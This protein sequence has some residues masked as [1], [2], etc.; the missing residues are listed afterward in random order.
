[1]RHAYSKT[2]IAIVTTALVTA[3]SG[4]ATSPAAPSSPSAGPAVANAAAGTATIA[5]S[6]NGGGVTAAFRPTSVGPITVSIAGSSMTTNVDGSGRFTLR[7]VPS[8]D[9]TLVFSSNG[10]N[11][12][13]VI[14]GVADH[15]QIQISVALSG[16]TAALDE[17]ERDEANNQAELEGRLTAINAAARTFV[18]AGVTVTVPTGTPVRHGDTAV[19]LSALVVGER[20]H[21][22]GTK[23]AANAMTA[24]EVEVQNEHANPGPGDDPGNDGHGGGE[25]ELEG[26]LSGL[27]GTCPTVTFK[28]SSATVMTNASTKFEDTTCATLSSAGRVEVKGTKQTNGSVLATKVEKK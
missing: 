22:H 10:V 23:T 1:M 18:V 14:A 5:G 15:E 19:A 8:G 6:V 2:V 26:T 12:Q 16:S 28:V 7:N 20:V 27:S 4:K 11:A 9:Q 3:C 24:S 13:L 17:N 25:A 21:V